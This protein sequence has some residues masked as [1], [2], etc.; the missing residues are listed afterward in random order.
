MI[1]QAGF[2]NA[3]TARMS[4]QIYELLSR[5]IRLIRGIVGV[6]TDCEIDASMG[7]RQSPIGLVTR[8]M[9]RD[10]YHPA[11]ACRFSGRKHIG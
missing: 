4:R 10:R 11:D 8:H 6:R 2:S 9:G 7:L 1:V 3:D 5:H